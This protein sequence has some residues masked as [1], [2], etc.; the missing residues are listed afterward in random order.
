MKRKNNLSFFPPEEKLVKM[1]EKMLEPNYP[2]ANRPLPE[3]VTI[4][5]E[6][7]YS[8]C[9]KILVYKQD[10][11]LT[12]GELAQQIDLTEPEVED[13][14]FARINKFTLDRLVYYAFKLFPFHLV[15]HEEQ[16]PKR[17]RK[18]VNHRHKAV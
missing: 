8:L 11:K 1:R 5:E 14:L 4:V 18:T 17:S 7:K 2:R 12:A 6:S 16:L 9:K 13:I 3:N 15:I 10:N